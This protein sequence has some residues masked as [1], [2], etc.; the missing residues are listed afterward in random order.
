MTFLFDDIVFGPVKSRRFGVSLGMNLLPLNYKYCTFNCIYCEC[1][2]TF[3]NNAEKITLP[4][5]QQIFDALES[6][7]LKMKEDGTAPDHITFAGNGEPTV[8]PQ[9]EEVIGDTLALRDRFFR[10][11]E[12]TVLSNAS[13]IHKE[14]VFRA[15]QQV[16]NNVLKLDSAVESTFR[17]INQPAGKM[18]LSSIIEHIKRFE[19]NQ[20]IQTLFLRGHHDGEYVDNTTGTEIVAWIKVLKEIMPKYVMI[21][22]IERD[23][24][25]S[26]IEKIPEEELESIARL[27][28]QE[29]IK[30]KLYY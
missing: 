3:K 1:G 20:V 10:D 7:L 30:T 23:T 26:G 27:V 9:F 16:D 11:A 18:S 17:K 13:L 29:G 12:L 5:R 19:G 25:A 24:A 15:L 14:K 4:T 22:P 2:W 28:E 8:H 6:R 21:Y